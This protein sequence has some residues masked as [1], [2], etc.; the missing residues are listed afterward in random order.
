MESPFRITVW[1]K[2]FTRRGFLG[3]PV[4][5]TVNLRHNAQSGATIL[6][7]TDH[8]LVPDLMTP[9]A[10]V[11]VDYAGDQVLSGPVVAREG[12]G[13]P[14]GL[15]TVTVEDDWRLLTRILGWPNPTGSITQQGAATSYNTASGSAE[16]VVKTL[17]QRNI[18]RLGLPVTV[19]TNQ[20]RGSTISAK[21]RMHPLWD[22]LVIAGVLTAGVGFT[23][24]QNGSAG[25]VL[26][27]YATGTYP[28]VLTPASGIVT[29]WSWSLA[30][31]KATRTVVGGQGEGTAREFRLR[32]SPPVESEFGDVVEVF[33][34]ARGESATTELDAAGD[35]TLAEGSPTTGLS[36]TLAET[37]TFRYGTSV[38][39][40]DLVTAQLVLGAPS[41]TDVLSEAVLTWT[42]AEGFTAAP[43]V[44]ERQDDP[45]RTL[46]R[47]VAAIARAVR[48]VNART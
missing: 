23:V 43:V 16:N 33:T 19:A 10:R 5:V 12:T 31:P 6:I 39:V 11:T 46:A 2:T 21:V 30:G 45:N 13:D 4:A 7:P 41:I 36:L 3:D 44:G 9:G 38:R 15:L 32:T 27:A 34:D 40:G 14:D 22:R 42:A 48:N 35:T 26:D 37:D 28:R 18:T 25:L 20:G 17:A 24:R 29:A 47:A 1:S 8:R